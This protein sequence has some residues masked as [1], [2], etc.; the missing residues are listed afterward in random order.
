MAHACPARVNLQRKTA[1]IHMGLGIA[2]D[3]KPRWPIC[4][5]VGEGASI[6]V[7][8]APDNSAAGA[9]WPAWDHHHA[10]RRALSPSRSVG[11][12]APGAARA[13]RKRAILNGPPPE[14]SAA[15]AVQAA[16]TCRLAWH[17]PRRRILPVRGEAM[18]R[19]RRLMARRHRARCW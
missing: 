1:A 5:I 8:L 14:A 17:R 12:Q 15:K 3:L 18:N 13:G 16:L 10:V 2:V 6:Q 11:H 9:R 7:N 19:L 4:G